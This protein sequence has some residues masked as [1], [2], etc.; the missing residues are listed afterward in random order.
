MLRLK[1]NEGRAH[2]LLW[3]NLQYFKKTAICNTVY[4]NAPSLKKKVYPYVFA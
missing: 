4:E 3:N 1:M 2:G